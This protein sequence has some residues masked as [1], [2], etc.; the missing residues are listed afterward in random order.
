MKLSHRKIRLLTRLLLLAGMFVQGTLAAHAC[1]TSSET[2]AMIYEL[3]TGT[4]AKPCH[5]A[6]K[7]N[8]NACLIHCTQAGQVNLD[9]QAI[10]VLPVTEVVLQVEMPQIQQ[11][12]VTAAFTSNT[13]NTG[14]PRTIR[15]CTFQI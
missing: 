15:F 13:S 4:G 9:H 1:V 10:A 11:G 14:P 5:D 7:T 2:A 6:E 3:E 8:A 12:F